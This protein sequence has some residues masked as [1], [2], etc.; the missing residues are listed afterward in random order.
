MVR[1]VTLSLCLFLVIGCDIPDRVSRLEREN[2]DLKSQIERDHAARDFDLQ[3]KCSKDAQAWFNQNW[4]RDKDTEYLKFTNHYNRKS[5]GCFVV[6][7][8]HYSQPTGDKL[9]TTWV[10]DVSLWN[11]YE[12]DQIGTFDERHTS[13][14]HGN[15]QPEDHVITCEVDQKK[16][17][18]L[19]GFYDLIRPYMSD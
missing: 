7:E 11:L 5:N 17:S 19:D 15:T 6:V 10:N 12:N 8:Y 18:S 3:G 16:C 4:A 13:N 9:I 14:Y 2:A 1:S